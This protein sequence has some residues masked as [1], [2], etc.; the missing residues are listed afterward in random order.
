MVDDDNHLMPKGSKYI[1]WQRYQRKKESRSGI[2][3]KLFP[4]IVYALPTQALSQKPFPSDNFN[5]N[6][7]KVIP[8][9]DIL[10]DGI[11]IKQDILKILK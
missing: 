8:I 11:Q 4:K 2:H 7:T 1:K 5:I 6:S 3:C 9:K 10:I